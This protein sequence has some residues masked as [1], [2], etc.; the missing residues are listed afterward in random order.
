[1]RAIAHRPQNQQS[2]IICSIM[3]SRSTQ[4]RIGLQCMAEEEA[5]YSIGLV[6]ARVLWD[7]ASTSIGNHLRTGRSAGASCWKLSVASEASH[8]YCSSCHIG[9]HPASS[10]VRPIELGELTT[11]L[12]GNPKSSRLCGM[13]RSNGVGVITQDS[14][15]SRISCDPG[16]IPG[17]TYIFAIYLNFVL[18]QVLQVLYM[19]A[20]QYDFDELEA[21]LLA[22]VSTQTRFV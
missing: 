8:W 12:T 1:M 18:P 21:V 3:A 16:S 14:D 22:Q 6:V 20:S 9:S 5:V 17:W 2:T 19:F 15:K 11:T 4:C 10:E 13:Q 7:R